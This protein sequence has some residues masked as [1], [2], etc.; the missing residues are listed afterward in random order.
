MLRVMKSYSFKSGIMVLLLNMSIMC[1]AQ[2]LP[3]TYF[4]ATSGKLSYGLYVPENYDS[5]KSYPLVMHLH[6]WSWTHSDYLVWY[7]PN[8]QIKTPCFVYTPKTPTTWGDWSGWNDHS[9]SE[10]MISA[11]HVLDSL[12]KKYSVDTNRLY[13]YGI[14]MGGEGTFDLLH[15]LPGKFAAA[16]SVCGGGQSWWA[17]EIA[18]TPFWMF[19]GSDDNINPP[20]ITERV[21]NELVRIGA[22]NM[23]YTNYSGYGHEIWDKA[24]NEPAWTEWMFAFDKSQA[25]YA[26]PKGKINL[27][28]T[29]D[30][31]LHLQWND[32][33]NETN[34]ADK[35]WYYT[36]FDSQGFLATVEFD[37]LNYIFTPQSS[38]DTFKV[39]AVNYNFK[40]SEFSNYLY[41]SNNSITS[42][43]PKVVTKKKVQVLKNRN[44][45]L[46]NLFEKSSSPIV[47]K[48]FSLDGKTLFI[49]EY[50]PSN[51]IIVDASKLGKQ[52]I[53]VNILLEKQLYSDKVIFD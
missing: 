24:A 47:V 8:L 10:P 25:E 22:K 1:F 17:G 19:H 52:I 4:E 39:Q 43:S 33:R 36:I 35:I 20:E 29:F 3:K 11:I 44:S 6:G 30:G 37:V 21:Y 38:I 16:M 26:S 27:S 45:I 32:I 49:K 31:Q 48:M 34:N 40:K 13:V 53:I 51:Q 23:R 2:E 41:F 42:S 14:S 46:I 28:G 50:Q 12:T 9:L 5:T 15:K 7:S 18:K